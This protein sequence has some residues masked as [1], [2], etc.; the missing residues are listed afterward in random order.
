VQST[1]EPLVIERDGQPTVVMIPF[2]EYQELVALR[3]S[4]RKKAWQAEQEHL[5]QKQVAAFERMKPRL[6]ETHRGKW[7]AIL[8]ERL[9]DSDADRSA[10]SRR[11]SAKFARQP[12]LIDQVLDKPRVY[13]ID[14]PERVRR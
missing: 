7:V 13:V 4:E 5:F 11:V 8:D 2:P 14:S 12:M 6:L 3:E 1:G 9:V 10:L